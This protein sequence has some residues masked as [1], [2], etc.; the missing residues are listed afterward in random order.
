M[1]MPNTAASDDATRCIR[2]RA[3]PGCQAALYSSV[4]SVWQHAAARISLNIEGC[5]DNDKKDSPENSNDQNLPCKGKG[6]QNTSRVPDCGHS[7]R[8][9]RQQKTRRA[10]DRAS[11]KRQRKEPT[12]E[13]ES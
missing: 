2:L 13:Q 11:Q 4:P 5:K 3:M 9:L 7:N 10:Q 1:K 12:I 8:E 6:K